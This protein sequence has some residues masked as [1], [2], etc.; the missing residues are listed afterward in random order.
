VSI[1]G[2]MGARSAGTRA[3]LDVVYAVDRDAWRAWLRRTHATTPRVWLVYYRKA[4]GKT[5]VSYDDAVEEALAFGWIDSKTNP[6]DDERYLQLFTPRRPGVSDEA[7]GARVSASA[8]SP[9]LH[10]CH[11]RFLANSARETYKRF[12]T[13]V[14]RF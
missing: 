4:T 14:A 8:D 3:G 13:D 2:S 1:I 12:V 5:G 9:L 7:S 11:S 6:L 10:Y